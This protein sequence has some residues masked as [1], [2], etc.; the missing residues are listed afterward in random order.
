M[1]RQI[2]GEEIVDGTTL[3]NI[4]KMLISKARYEGYSAESAV[5]R[6]FWELV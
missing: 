5:I 3:P 2:K 4:V 1:M 6:W